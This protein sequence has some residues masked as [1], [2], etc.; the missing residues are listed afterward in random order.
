MRTRSRLDAHQLAELRTM[1]E[2]QRE[3]RLDQLTAL[4]RPN[5]RSPLRGRHR[6]ITVALTVGAETALADVL[7]ALRRMDEGSYGTCERC[8]ASI[9]IE[10]L[11]VLPQAA[12]CLPC[13][14]GE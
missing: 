8:S 5:S 13:Q 12:L 3:F 9:E 4:R 14:T 7:A 6:E 10:R 2:E 11:E 1:L